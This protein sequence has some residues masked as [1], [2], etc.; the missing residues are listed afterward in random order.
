MSRNIKKF[1]NKAE[2][3]TYRNST[4]YVEPHVSLI[5]NEPVPMFNDVTYG[6]ESIPLTL[7]ML[8]DG[9]VYFCSYN[10]PISYSI[11]N[12][13]WITEDD[14]VTGEY[15]INLDAGDEISFKGEYGLYAGPWQ[16]SIWVGK[17][18]G[19]C[20]KFNVKGNIMSIY[21]ADDF[22]NQ[23]TVPIGN[24][25]GSG[26][27]CGAFAYL[28][29][30]NGGLISSKRLIL[31]ATTVNEDAYDGMFN[32]CVNMK[33]APKLPATTLG[34]YC[35][36]QMFYNCESL[37]EAPDLPA[38]TLEEGC[39]SSMFS[40]CDSLTMAPDLPATTL[41]YYCYE[42]M[43]YGCYDLNYVKCLCLTE[44]SSMYTYYWLANCSINGKVI[45]NNDINW[46][47]CWGVNYGIPD[48]W[49]CMKEDGTPFEE[50]LAV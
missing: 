36:R 48:G 34:V 29:A 22:E 44:L 26:G 40:Y 50:P 25:G 31:P 19:T 9:T 30:N 5:G 37:K 13:N 4:N 41:E 10:G 35:Y 38:T 2:Y 45:L 12:G 43:F 20:S 47:P 18:N 33:D 27:T 14:N 17:S 1:A 7:E 28:F 39:Y 11:N 3:N 6:C 32:E 21:Y 49:I 24:D 46:E 23:T 15:E 8:E 42:H 16:S